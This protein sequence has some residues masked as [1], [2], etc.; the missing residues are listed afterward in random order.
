M[1][2]TVSFL[3][4][5]TGITTS[6]TERVLR[7][8][9]NSGIMKSIRVCHLDTETGD[10][11]GYAIR[12][13]SEKFFESIGLT[14]EMIKKARKR[15]S[16]RLK[17][18]ARKAKIKLV[19]LAKVSLVVGGNPV[20]VVTRARRWRQPR[21]DEREERKKVELFKALIEKFPEKSPSEIRIILDQRKD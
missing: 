17:K 21:S 13:V 19:N 4:R 11:R 18:L 10:Y 5:K 3:A 14:L 7:D 9:V 1:P 2:L 8:L 15:A 12:T 6:R 20:A 16:E